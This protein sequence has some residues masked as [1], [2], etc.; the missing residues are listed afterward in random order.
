[1]QDL[2]IY[3]TLHRKKELFQPIAAPNVGMYV[4]GPTVYGDPH[5]GHARPAITFDIL[6]RYLKHIGYKVRYVRNITDVGHLEHDADE[7]DD[8]I[9][10]KARL[11]QLEPMEIA[12]YYTNRYHDAMRAL[13]V[14]PPSIEPHATGHIIEQEELVKEILA[15]GYAYE[16]NGSVYFDV[17]K[18][19]KDHH[20]GVLSGR[21]ITDMIN[22]SRELAG[23]GEKRNQIDFALWKRAMPEHIMRWPSPWSNGFPGWHCEC[24]AMGRKYLGDHFDI[25]G[26]GMDLIF[27]HHECEI[28]QAVASQGD[29]MVKYWMHNNM[30][31]INGQKMGKSLGNFIT[32]EQFFTGKHDTLSQ[33]YSPMTIRFFILSAHYRGTVDFSNEA[34]QAAEKGYERL[35]NGIEDLARIQPSAASDENT[36]KFVAELRQKCYDAM[37]DDLMTP[38][39]ISNLFEACHLVNTIIDHK[40]QISADDLQE[41]TDT[42]KLFAF[43]IL[44]L[45]NERGANNDAREEAYGKVV[46]M[47]LDLRAKAKAEKNWAVS[48]QIRDSLAAAGFQV[49]DTKDGV[50]WKL[51][52]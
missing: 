51:D 5:L 15:N 22:N 25:H 30:I 3:N 13:N 17:E 33:A 50:T 1:M 32:L 36:K 52:R 38:A 18:Y 21:N 41:L 19:D 29:E 12:Q 8:K 31:T 39:V 2:V 9:E 20:Y 34:L 44:G 43:D 14:L 4:C 16:S 7:G 10:K 37:N 28:A 46:D 6:F 24:T 35:M 27:P 49:K 48:D 47:V 11:E 45:Q 23:V 40:A 42:M 26:G